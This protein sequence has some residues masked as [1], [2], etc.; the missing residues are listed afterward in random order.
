MKF[1]TILL[2]SST[3]LIASIAPAAEEDLER[4]LEAAQQ[5]LEAAADEVARLSMQLGPGAVMGNVVMAHP[6]PGRAVIGVQLDPKATP[7][8]ARVQSVSPGGPAALAGLVAGDTIASIGA[9]SLK[10]RDDAARVVTRR[11]AELPA[12][13]PVKLQVVRD[14]KVREVSITPRRDLTAGYALPMPPVPPGAPAPFVTALPAFGVARGLPFP[15]AEAI[16]GLEFATV[17]PGLGKYFGV[18][19][20]VLVVRAPAAGGIGLEEGDVIQSI[21]EREVKSA[22]HATRVLASYQSGEKVPIRLVRMK[23]PLALDRPM[24]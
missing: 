20:G 4:Q 5:K 9:E 3:L 16:A 8:G 10:G 7:A 1:V 18:E 11:L 21:G 17:T 22:S 2:A 19:A 14:G 13:E 23:K 12:G 24:P 15:G 6:V